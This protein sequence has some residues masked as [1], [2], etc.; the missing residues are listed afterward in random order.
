MEFNAVRGLQG[1]K[2]AQLELGGLKLS[3]AV[4]HGT[5]NAQKV[6]DSVR[7]GEKHYDFIEVMCCPGGCVTGGGQPI[8]KA[9]V[10]DTVNV[11]ALRAQALYNE[12]AGKARRKSQDNEEV[13]TLYKEYLGEIGG[14]KAHE[15]LHT[16]YTARD[17]YAGTDN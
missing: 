14:H 11:S 10:R 2:E 6:L 13:K 15:I 1:V 7:S 9:S 3:I 17:K 8:V 4:A 12:D 16:T 5:A